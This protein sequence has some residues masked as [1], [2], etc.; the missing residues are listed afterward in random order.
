MSLL[1][2]SEVTGVFSSLRKGASPLVDDAI[3]VLRTAS[4]IVLL[5]AAKDKFL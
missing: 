1:A 3:F 2:G 4:T 5:G